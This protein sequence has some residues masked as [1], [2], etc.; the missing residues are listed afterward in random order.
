MTQES[1]EIKEIDL[2]ELFSTIGQGIKNAFTSL[3]KGVIFLIVFGIKR[4]HW[5][6]LFAIAGGLVGYLMFSSTQRFYS[7]D[8]IA[9]PNGISAVDMVQ[10]INDLNR[11]TKKNNTIALSNALD[12]PD[13]IAKKIKSIEA[14]H[15]IDVN[16]DEIGDFVDFLHSYNAKD[17]NL[18]IDNQ[19][20]FLQVEV[21]DNKTFSSVKNGIFSYVEK[22]PYLIELNEIRKSELEELISS[23]GY[24]ISK[25]DSLQNVDY[26]KNNNRLGT[27]NDNNF[28]LLSEK[29]KPMYYKDKMYLTHQKQYYLKELKMATAPLTIIKDFTPLTMEENPKGSYIIKFGF[30]FGVIGYLVLLLFNKRKNLNQFIK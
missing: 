18:A 8:L 4:A 20:F 27:S 24:E 15:Y 14:F 28:M 9:Q 2:L 16:K 6:A 1:K 17:T 13:T 22:N 19:R 12:L 30:W 26:F 3:L 29:E 11:F 5:L 25:L 7:S 10:Y 23:I 21:Y